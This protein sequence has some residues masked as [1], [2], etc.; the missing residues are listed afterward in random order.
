MKRRTFIAGLGG[1]VAWQQGVLAQ[2]GKLPTIGLL[3]ANTAAAQSVWTA[4]FVGRLRELGWIEHR[5]VAIEYRWAEGRP[6]RYAEFA[7]EFVRL[8]VDVILTHATPATAAAKQATSVI[9]VVFAA[10]GNPVGTGLVG[11]LARP[12]G[13]I[14]GLSLQQTETVGKRIELLREIVPRLRTLAMMTNA[15]NPG[16]ALEIEE[17]QAAARSLNLK[18]VT[19]AVDRAEDIAPALETLKGGADALYVSPSPLALT[20][21]MRINTL[22]LNARLPT[23][24]LGKEYV[25]AGGLMSYGPNY[26]HLFR[27]AAELIDKILRGTKPS[28]IPVEQPTKFDLVINLIAAQALGLDIPPTLLTRADEVIE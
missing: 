7:A 10:A 18:V 16:S 26:P 4:A 23:I 3:G 24:F 13:N 27:R 12:G 15:S 21:V 6:E 20:N 28:D 22:A 1:V 25:Q 9:P 11:S 19:L 5:S 8:K 2:P 14:T 17:L